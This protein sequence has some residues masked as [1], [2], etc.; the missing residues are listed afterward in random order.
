MRVI[1][2][3][4]ANPKH[5]TLIDH[6]MQ[7]ET[8]LLVDTRLSPRSAVPG[9]HKTSLEQRYGKR[10]RWLGESLGNLNYKGGPIAIVN[11][12]SGIAALQ[13][14]LLQGHTVLLLCGCS[15]FETCHRHVIC[16]ALAE[17]WSEVEIVLPEQIIAKEQA[18][19]TLRDE[20]EALYMN[21]NNIKPAMAEYWHLP[22]AQQKQVRQQIGKR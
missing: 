21:L 6:L 20:R 11:L 18:L 14:L 4:Y 7:D 10:Y 2:V 19:T 3:G 5:R 12:G 1:P 16:D 15:V 17:Q 8:M 22:T 9:W 13:A